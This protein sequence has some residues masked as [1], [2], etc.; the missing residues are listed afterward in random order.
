MKIIILS[1]KR[2]TYEVTMFP[3]KNVIAIIA[4][5]LFS[6]ASQA[7]GFKENA[8]HDGTVY[9]LPYLRGNTFLLSQAEN[10]PTHKDEHKFAYDFQMPVGTPIYSSRAGKVIRVVDH[11]SDKA[12]TEE[13]KAQGNFILIEHSDG[14]YSI[15]A[16]L[17]KAG[18]LVKVGD[19]IPTAKKI[20]FS[21]NTGFTSG[22]HL[23]FEVFNFERKKQKSISVKFDVGDV[24][25]VYL[26]KLK[27][28]KAPSNCFN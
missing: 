23:H 16:H 24:A 7:Q 4:L 21:G 1:R 11:F 20:G 18:S 28:Y 22:P 6:F 12:Q 25:P 27:S 26:E 13:F 8:I 3:I 5:I 9:C 15:Y 14:T 17:D 19:K 10:G 2:L